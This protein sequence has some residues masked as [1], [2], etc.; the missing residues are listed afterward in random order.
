M[1]CSSLTSGLDFLQTIRIL[2]LLPRK[3]KNSFLGRTIYG[4][5][6]HTHG[7]WELLSYT[8]ATY[9]ALTALVQTLH[10][11]VKTGS[12]MAVNVGNYGS[13]QGVIATCS[14]MSKHFLCLPQHLAKEF[15]VCFAPEGLGKA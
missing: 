12:L 11:G 2:A 6:V 9:S 1:N 3:W 10:C 14:W 15:S 8:G 13:Y 4:V 5:I 7:V